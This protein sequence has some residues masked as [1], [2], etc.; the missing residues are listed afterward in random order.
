MPQMPSQYHLDIPCIKETQ[1]LRNT[2]LI[3]P[4][5]SSSYFGVSKRRFGNK[6]QV[7]PKLFIDDLRNPYEP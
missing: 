2:H 1:L 4:E 3:I 7:S 6:Y 5:I